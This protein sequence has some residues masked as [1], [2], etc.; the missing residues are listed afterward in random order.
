[1]T[2][3]LD[4]ELTHSMLIYANAPYCFCP[5]SVSGS[6]ILV[7]VCFYLYSYIPLYLK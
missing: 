1:M 6:Y 2:A 4:F 5:E 3:R 7:D